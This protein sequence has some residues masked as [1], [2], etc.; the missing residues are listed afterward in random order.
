MSIILS[1]FRKKGVKSLSQYYI[2]SINKFISS[3]Y[4][5]NQLVS[6]FDLFRFILENDEYYK[7]S[8]SNFD[9]SVFATESDEEEKD[10]FKWIVVQTQSKINRE[11]NTYYFK[12]DNYGNKGFFLDILMTTIE[13]EVPI[14]DF[15]F[16]LEEI[17]FK[18]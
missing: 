13:N 2:N 6:F 17:F 7:L 4:N 12:K 15:C 8:N 14:E 5:E 9:I 11:I 18:L 3:Y 10:N 1:D 16:L